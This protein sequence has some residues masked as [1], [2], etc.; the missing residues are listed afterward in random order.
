MSPERYETV[1][2][3]GAAGFVGGHLLAHLAEAP[4]KSVV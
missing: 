3:T 2:V 1:V 4:R